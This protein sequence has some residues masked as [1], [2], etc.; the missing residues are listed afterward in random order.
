MRT[1][2]PVAIGNRLEVRVHIALNDVELRIDPRLGYEVGGRYREDRC[3]R[4]LT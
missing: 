2:R 1:P 4:S 3:R